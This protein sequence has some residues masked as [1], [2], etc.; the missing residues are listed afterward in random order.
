[1]GVFLLFCRLYIIER[2]FGE[3]SGNRGVFFEN[4]RFWDPQVL[5]SEWHLHKKS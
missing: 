4:V 1:V 2:L 3:R 5:H